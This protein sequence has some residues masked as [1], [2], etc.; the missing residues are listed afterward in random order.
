MTQTR[1]L[2]DNAQSDGLNKK[3][4]SMFEMIFQ[5]SSALGEI[6]H[7]D[8]SF[9]SLFVRADWVVRGVMIIL[10]LA[11]VWSWVVAVNKAVAI[12]K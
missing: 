7:G 3:N 11:S 1:S 12:Y 10:A 2:L 4:T 5:T 9:W 6:S 8:F